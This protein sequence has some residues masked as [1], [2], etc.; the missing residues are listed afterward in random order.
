MKRQQLFIRQT[1]SI[2]VWLCIWHLV[3]SCQN[4]STERYQ[5]SDDS[6]SIFQDQVNIDYAIGFDVV[7]TMKTGKSFC[8]LG[9]TMI[10]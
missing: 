7:Y 9:T 8:F 2:F 10:L 6:K 4:S 3:S 1:N 5:S